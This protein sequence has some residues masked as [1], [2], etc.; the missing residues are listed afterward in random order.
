V[1]QR[2][3]LIS[4]RPRGG[5]SYSDLKRMLAAAKE[6]QSRPEAGT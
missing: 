5:F 6:V 4:P 1:P 2:P 3:Q